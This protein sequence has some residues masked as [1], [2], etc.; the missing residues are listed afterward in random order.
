LPAASA[1]MAGLLQLLCCDHQAMHCV[2]VQQLA[3]LAYCN[4]ALDQL[5]VGLATKPGAVAAVV[6][7]VQPWSQEGFKEASE[8]GSSSHKAAKMAATT[9]SATHSPDNSQ[10]VAGHATDSS[11]ASCTPTPTDTS[12]SCTNDSST[13][14][15][16]ASTHST[17]T[18]S[19]T[20]T[21]SSSSSQWP[22]GA[23]QLQAEAAAALMVLASLGKSSREAVTRDAAT[24]GGLLRALSNAPWKPADQEQQQEQQTQQQERRL[25]RQQLADE[26]PSLLELVMGLRRQITLRTLPTGHMRYVVSLVFT[27]MVMWLSCCFDM[28]LHWRAYLWA[29]KAALSYICFNGSWSLIK[30]LWLVA[31][32]FGW[33]LACSAASLGAGVCFEVLVWVISPPILALQEAFTP[34]VRVFRG[35]FG[36]RSLA[37]PSHNQWVRVRQQWAAYCLWHLLCDA[38]PSKHVW[39]QHAALA[40]QVLV[41]FFSTKPSP[42]PCAA[43]FLV[44]L[45]VQSGFFSTARRPAPE[46]RGVEPPPPPHLPS[47]WRYRLNAFALTAVEQAWADVEGHL[48]PAMYVAGVLAMVSSGAAMLVHLPYL[49]PLQYVAAFSPLVSAC[50][51]CPAT[52][53]ACAAGL[54]ALLGAVAAAVVMVSSRTGSHHLVVASRPA[55]GAAP[56][57]TWLQP[58]SYLALDLWPTLS[59]E[60]AS[61][62]LAKYECYGQWP[63]VAPFHPIPCM[64]Q[65]VVAARQGWLDVL[66]RAQWL[67]LLWA[68]VN[69]IWRS[70]SPGVHPEASEQDRVFE[71]MP[72][73]VTTVLEFVAPLLHIVTRMAFLGMRV[74]GVLLPVCCAVLQPSYAPVRRFV[75]LCW[76]LVCATCKAGMCGFSGTAPMFRRAGSTLLSLPC[77]A[78]W[79]T[80]ACVDAV[81]GGV[82]SAAGAVGRQALWWLR[83][84]LRLVSGVQSAMLAAGAFLT[85]PATPVAAAGDSMPSPQ[86]SQRSSTAPGAHSTVASSTTQPQGKQHSETAVI[87]AGPRQEK[88]MTHPGPAA[89]SSSISTSRRSGDVGSQPSGRS[90]SRTDTVRQAGPQ[91]GLASAAGGPDHSAASTSREA[92]ATAA[93]VPTAAAGAAPTDA[94]PAA[95]PAS[96]GGGGSA[97]STSSHTLTPPAT[98]NSSIL[99][100]VHDA[101]HDAGPSSIHMP[102]ASEVSSTHSS[103]TRT[104]PM[105]LDLG[106][107]SSSGS[108][109]SPSA[110]NTPAVEDQRATLA[111]AQQAAHGAARAAA[112]AA[113]AAGRPLEEV[114]LAAARA[115]AEALQGAAAGVP[116]VE[117]SLLVVQAAAAAAGLYAGGGA[118]AAANSVA[119]APSSAPASEASDASS[120]AHTGPAPAAGTAATPR[121]KKPRSRAECVVCLDARPSVTTHPCGHRVLCGGCAQLVAASK[122]E[123][124]MCRAPVVRYAA[125]HPGRTG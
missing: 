32:V 70:W 98:P 99:G 52:A 84:P 26:P 80:V 6:A 77:G 107:G 71:S 38:R 60:G 14:D 100:L 120:V 93:A 62:S 101:T 40:K 39:Q 109:S 22:G 33:K 29:C 2:V 20:N 122:G 63:P 58:V 73:W 124:P 119:P 91:E 88:V 54:Q 108:S 17:A 92:A 105:P 114:H 1:A 56:P 42:N 30:S 95:P 9:S 37:P 118:L 86:H 83:L 16:P 66:G 48:M 47:T 21:T 104:R 25:Q 49:G 64:A 90:G 96:A 116:S 13:S 74:V 36:T 31:V 113:A 110:P 35:L 51:L 78:W 76:W 43:Q 27:L 125:G 94:V 103:S 10:T 18:L 11:G 55:P 87:T 85:Q 75:R 61:S 4:T 53:G 69:F 28:V 44:D 117:G 59:T 19:S 111:A 97:V 34:M 102:A 46:L 57:R 89:P 67:F 23:A 50:I 41:G 15:M 12:T 72:A 68:M 106:T 112:A 123:C 65:H 8:G 3:R 5:G 79:C 45:A 81:A 121:P 24:L 82:L 7:L 115:A